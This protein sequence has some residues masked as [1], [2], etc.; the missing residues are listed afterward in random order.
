MRSFFALLP[1]AYL[2]HTT[3]ADASGCYLGAFVGN[4]PAVNCAVVVHQ[5]KA[6]DTGNPKLF[7][8]RDGM[9][10]DVTGTVDKQEITLPVVY[11]ETD[12]DGAVISAT[13]IDE[14]YNVYRVTISGG[15]VGEALL[16]DGVPAGHIQAQAASCVEPAA[17]QPICGHLPL[18]C[19]LNPP[20]EDHDDGGCNSGRGAGLALAGLALVFVR[21][22]RR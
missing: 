10:V 14:A 16:V 11:P 15:L 6:Y 2:L 19:D 8:M 18:D 20:L 1:V 3:P 9:Q 5:Y 22:R 13:T 12:C 7:V 21:K 4:D 17:P